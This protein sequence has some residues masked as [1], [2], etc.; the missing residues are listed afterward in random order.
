M[1][2]RV[3]QAWSNQVLM[4]AW[5]RSFV[6][7]RPR[8]RAPEKSAVP[9]LKR[10]VEAQQDWWT[11]L[12]PTQPRPAVP[13][14][15]DNELDFAAWQVLEHLRRYP[16]SPESFPRNASQLLRL[17]QEPD[18]DFNRVVQLAGQ[19]HAVAGRLL[20]LANAA[21]HGTGEVQSVRGAVLRLGIEEVVHVALG[22]A[23]RPLFQGDSKS[24]GLAFV[25]CW[26]SQFHVSMTAAF[27]AGSI[28]IAARA[29]QPDCAFLAG[30]FHDIGK[31]IALRSVAAL[32]ASG[33]L[34]G[35]L[36]G[37]GV[38]EVLQRVHVEVGIAVTEAWGLPLYL[39]DATRRHHDEHVDSKDT[40]EL[41]IVRLADGMQAAR[42]GSLD[43]AKRSAVKTSAIA[44]GLGTARLRALATE[45][46]E[47]A[48]RVSK[49]FGVA[50]P[51]M[52]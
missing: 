50:D 30:M 34:T 21:A 33:E 14:L 19:D 43:E 16:A 46:L 26:E 52:R 47:H 23:G 18:P 31:S 41:H 20:Q 10:V 1:P 29:G 2:S 17:L 32:H 8:A 3:L 25:K 36:A 40:P 12:A 28:A 9:P 51:L 5:L 6:A 15:S 4:L 48:I 37:H 42:D 27:T 45:H 35:N 13:S 39:R 7:P 49:I 22:I 24:V 11:A 44:L 38:E